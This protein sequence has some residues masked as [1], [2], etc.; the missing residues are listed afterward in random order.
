[1]ALHHELTM[2]TSSRGR[3][4][5]KPDASKD[6]NDHLKPNQQEAKDYASSETKIL[7]EL[8]KLR[9]ENREGH[10]QTKMS[11]KKLETS[12]EDLK[13]EMT[14][15]EKRTQEVEDRV[16]ATEDDG[17]KYERAIR[18][19]LRRER[20]LTARCEDLQNRTR[21]NNMTI[22]WV[23]EGSEGKDVK[24]FVAEMIQLVLKPM[25]DVNMQIERAHRSLVSKPKTPNA[26]PRSLIVR[27]VDYSVKDKILR[28]AWSQKLTYKDEQIYFDH[29]Y[30]PELQRK[31][32]QVREIIKQLKDKNVKAKC[33]YPAQLKLT[34]EKGEQIYP[35]L[36][37]A[38]PILAEYN[39]H[40]KIDE[41]AQMEDEMS[42][43]SWNVVGER[44]EEGAA[45]GTHSADDSARYD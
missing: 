13:G 31:R 44:R 1:M 19:L 37:E 38:L 11:L 29:D 20:D 9:A 18:Y 43:F 26:T 27:F 16:S 5:T 45:G 17:R 21:R 28:Q 8:E 35:T 14:K 33:L 2:A 42:S 30:S 25:P 34:T 32:A 24:K 7:A 4:A 23:P 40:P 39:I 41:R 15:L 22:Y 10:N 6:K 36:K 12:M 3:P